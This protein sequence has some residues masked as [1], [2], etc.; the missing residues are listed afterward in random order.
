MKQII[1]IVL[2]FISGCYSSIKIPSDFEYKEIETNKFTL[3]SWQKISSPD[4]DY[5]VYI[6]GDGNSFNSRGY[7]TTDPTPR[8]LTVRKLAFSDSSANVIYLSRP[9]QYVKDA[10]CTSNL[11]W[12]TGRFSKE[13]IFSTAQAIKSI[14]GNISVTLI[15]FSGGGQIV[16]LLSVLYP[17]LP[18]KKVITIAGNLD[19]K[20]WTEER[21]FLPLSDSL[22]LGDY[23][24]DFLQIPQ[25]HYVGS[26]DTV[27]P[28]YLT[29]N[30]IGDNSL[31]TEIPKAS[32]NQGWSVINLDK[33]KK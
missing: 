13:V 12:T 20:S 16:G 19:H 7:P 2:F 5:K 26:K 29:Y 25:H 28:P 3:A 14:V 10:E 11:Y 24:E 1:I 18:I 9:C 27:I 17:E 8:A 30:F 15:G 31:I 32:H 6:E 23:K 21:N 33:I 22:F 4:L